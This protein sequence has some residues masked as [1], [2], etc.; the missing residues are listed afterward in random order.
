MKKTS[1][2]AALILMSL[3]FTAYLMAVLLQPDNWADILSPIN[4]FLAG[5][6]LFIAFYRSN[7]K[8]K[9]SYGL[10]F[11]SLACFCWALADTLWAINTL[12][13]AV[14]PSEIVLVTFF[15]VLT[16]IFLGAGVLLYAIDQFKRWNI[17]KLLLD[18]VVFSFAAILLIWILFFN[19]SNEIFAILTVEGT[20]SVISIVTDILIYIGMVIWYLSIRGG[21][22]PP[23]VRFVSSGIFLFVL[24][25]L[26]Y[27][28][29]AYNNIYVVNSL[30]DAVYLFSLLI[31]AGGG[32]V[33]LSFD[34]PQIHLSPDLSSNTG[35]RSKEIF[36]LLCPLLVILVRGFVLAEFLVFISL[37]VVYMALNSY[38][39]NSIK[40]EELLKK[41]LALNTELESIIAARTLE[42]HQVN[43]EL[44]KKNDALSYLSNMDTLT[45]LYNRRYFLNYLDDSIA[46]I[47]DH[48]TLTLF[49]MDLDRFKLINDTYGHHMGDRVLLEISRRLEQSADGNATIAR[50]GGDEFV[51][52][53]TGFADNA[54]AIEMAK[55]IILNCSQELFINGYVFYPAL[56]I[57]ISIYPHDAEDAEA[58]IK[59]ADI[60]LYHA[61]SLGINKFAG[62]DSLIHDKNQ[63]RNEIELFLRRADFFKDLRLYYQPQFSIPDRKLA[64]VEALIRWV[65]ADNEIMT[66]QEFINI[67]EETDHINE[68]GLWVLKEAV[69]QIVDWNTRF[70]QNLRMGINISP[71]QLNS[72]NLLTEL[73]LLAQNQAF[74]PQW[75]DIEL[76]ENIAMDGEYRMSQIFKLFKSIGL[77][78][79][80]DDFGTGY[81]SISYLKHFTIDRIKIAKPLIDS[82]VTSNKD[83]QIVQAIVL[84][85]KTIGI[86]TIAEGVETS[87]QLDTLAEIGCEQ[88][89]GFYLGKP[90]PADQ[91]EHLFLTN[92]L[93]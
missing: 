73:N 75:L 9:I 74:N 49:Y 88:I 30:I 35:K 65:S 61:K 84:L 37:T 50:M 87:E 81:S 76:T 90:V 93:N 13:L 2:I 21:R 31:V 43:D 33:N 1:I 57:G 18:I 44:V 47:N 45:N 24:T 19:R 27:Y 72:T 15:Y 20:F 59:N 39:Q 10:L 67:A 28:Y 80:I 8:V 85:A 46:K 60:A 82:I 62:Y 26:Y 69:T 3:F 64:G 77:S 42:L 58:L 52:A 6:V 66:P 29:I 32:L 56:C 11:F 91:F 40:N 79:S 12:A 68:I 78:V 51:L 14:D 54:A 53:A 16:N 22:I 83:R 23:V 4:A 92:N 34:Y 71:K 55:T 7:R 17:A 38:L 36:I 25:D 89:Q 70:Q 86:Q 5:T 41:E 63:K 48:Q